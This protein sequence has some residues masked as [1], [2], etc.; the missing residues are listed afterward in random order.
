MKMKDEGKE[1]QSRQI[2]NDAGNSYQAAASYLLHLLLALLAPKN[3]VAS[4]WR[5]NNR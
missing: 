3:G 1:K 4:S 5:Q 2:N